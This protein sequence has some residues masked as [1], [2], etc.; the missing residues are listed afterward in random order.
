MDR[1]LRAAGRRARPSL[2]APATPDW[3]LERGQHEKPELVHTSQC[4]NEF[5]MQSVTRE[6]AIEAL[7][8][9]G[10]S[11]CL[12]WEPDKDLGVLD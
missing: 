6:Q 5:S 10:V 3:A 4:W 11:A 7:T 9:G 2:A 1:R 8:R 12:R